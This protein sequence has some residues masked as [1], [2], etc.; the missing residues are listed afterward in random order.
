M[1]HFLIVDDEP[2]I[3]YLLYE[4]FTPH[5]KVTTATAQDQALELCQTT[6]FDLILSDIKLHN[7]N[8]FV[9]L[10]QAKKYQPQALRILMTAYDVN[11]FIHDAISYGITNIIAKTI[12]LNFEE[13]KIIVTSLL[14]GPTFGIGR[15]LNLDTSNLIHFRL[16]STDEITDMRRS[17]AQHFGDTRRGVGDIIFLLDEITSNALYHANVF[18]D[19]RPK[20]L[21]PEK[22]VLEDTEVIEVVCGYDNSR[23]VVSVTDNAGTLKALTVLEKIARN[24]SGENLNDRS[25]RGLYVSRMLS[26]R[27]VITIEPGIKTEIILMNYLNKTFSGFKSLFINEMLP[28]SQSPGE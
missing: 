28:L 21:K 10:E 18:T 7:D 14:E 3:C 1:F 23:Y 5:Y 26:D 15:F 27:M 11:T 24:L 8:G 13:I 20:Y 25:G 2:D 19:G 12:P 22:V 6:N 17:I 4:L 16:H 9:F